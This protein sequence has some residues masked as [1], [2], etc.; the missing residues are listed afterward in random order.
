MRPA[1]AGCKS[2]TEASLSTASACQPSSGTID[3]PS[4]C[5]FPTAEAQDGKG[6]I[7]CPCDCRSNPVPPVVWVRA[8]VYSL[9]LPRS[10]GRC[11]LQAAVRAPARSFVRPL[12]GLAASARLSVRRF[13]G[14]QAQVGEGQSR[15]LLEMPLALLEAKGS[16]MR[17]A[18]RCWRLLQRGQ[19][20]L[21]SSSPIERCCVRNPNVDTFD[22]SKSL[23]SLIQRDC[24][25]RLVDI[26]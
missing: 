4:S 2:P 25:S 18:A 1:S 6:W 24:P 15:L 22:S 26:L 20:R 17:S 21:A 10:S 7:R 8:R 12:V 14:P 5:E 11:R 9:S 16:Q 13:Q 3:P 19:C 23:D